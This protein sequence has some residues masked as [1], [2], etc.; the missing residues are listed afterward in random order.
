[1][2]Q[3]DTKQI[4]QKRFNKLSKHYEAL[5]DYKSLI[6]NLLLEKNIYEQ[7]TFNTL[8]PE[9][10]AILDAYL[11]RFSSIQDFLGVKIFPLLLIVAGINSSKMSEVLYYIEKEEIIDS[12]EKIENYYLN[13]LNFAKKIYKMRLDNIVL[14]KIKEAIY[15]SFGNVNIYL[16]GSRTDDMKKGGDI[17]LAIDID[18]SASQFRKNKIKVL[19][20]LFKKDFDFKIDIVNYNTKDLLLK[21]QIEKRAILI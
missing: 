19:T 6:N 4:L 8:K 2:N 21:N 3:T 16:F 17:D 9:E 5:R 18:I 11:K 7:F 13:S 12:F 15:D 10:K 14:N 20:N 1:M